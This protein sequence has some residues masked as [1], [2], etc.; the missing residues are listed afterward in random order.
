MLHR[1]DLLQF[2]DFVEGHLNK[3]SH[4][5]SQLPNTIVYKFKLNKIATI[6]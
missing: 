6:F 1:A 2:V 5:N 3:S 4:K